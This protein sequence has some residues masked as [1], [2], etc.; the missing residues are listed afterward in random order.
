MISDPMN[1]LI[2]IAQAR[3]TSRFRLS[4]PLPSLAALAIT[5]PLSPTRRAPARKQP[6]VPWWIDCIEGQGFNSFSQ[7]APRS[8]VNEERKYCLFARQK[9]LSL[10]YTMAAAVV[11]K[12]R[13]WKGATEME[14]LCVCMCVTLVFLG[15]GAMYVK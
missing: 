5:A 3:P 14:L 10:L 13:G 4:V 6:N 1:I 7:E 11:V 9:L 12:H 15:E 8:W 2:R